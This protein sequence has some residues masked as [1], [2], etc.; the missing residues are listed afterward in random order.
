M[1]AT[2]NKHHPRRRAKL[3]GTLSVLMAVGFASSAQALDWLFEPSVGASVMY[4]D[5][6][7][8]S[9]VNEESAFILSATPGFTLQSQGS[10]RVEATMSYYLTGVARTA[11]T[12]DNDLYH[13]LNATGK[14]ELVEDLLFIDA[15]ARVSQELISLLGSPADATINSSNRA[16]VG[17]YSIS[18]YIKKRLGTF[19]DAEARYTLYGSLFN[20]NVATDLLTNQFDFSLN[21][22]TR[23][24]DL[25]WGLNYTY[26]DVTAQET[27]TLSDS[28]VYQRADLSLG[29]ALTRKFRLIGNL[30]QEKL[31]Y[32]I[33]KENDIDD[34]IWSAG[35]AWAPS[36]RTSIEATAGQ[37]FFG[38]TYSLSASYRAREA[39][40]TASYVEDVS[41]I[42][43]TQLT[44]GTL[45]LYLCPGTVPTDP[46]QFVYSPFLVSPAP[47][48]ILLGSQ[49]S[50]LPSIAEGLYVSKTFRAGL[51][52]GVR[53]VTYSINAS[54][55]RRIYLL[56]NNAEDHSQGIRAA[57]NY[58][59]DPLTSLYGNLAFD[60]IEDAGVLSGLGFD[61]E[62]ELLTFTLGV[63]RQ[64]GRD[65]T[66]ALTFR[67]YQRD[68]ND[69][70]AEYTE[71][72]IMASVNM[73]F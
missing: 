43:R 72:N 19:A 26:R 6:V 41:D 73:R 4:T 20:E 22:G 68:S 31:N 55:V 34:S 52:W 18:P 32:E 1:A 53:K 71:N 47:G 12:S 28:Y 35:F 27:N 50:L 40:L 54:D 5:N 10:R 48:C 9:P 21:S 23:F 58:R 8:Q 13:N 29:Y 66:G 25:N 62:D 36:R 2:A 65:L 63:T 42:S 44:E 38:D 17:S 70:T 60:W 3:A 67:H 37:R 64:F 39:A 11:G 56:Q 69:P 45:Y 24:N 7:N 33:L 46:P 59:L 57:V 61:R 15:S 30:G 49:P 51:N 16:T 14:A